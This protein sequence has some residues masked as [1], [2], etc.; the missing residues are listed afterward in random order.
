M[1]KKTKTKTMERAHT[2][3]SWTAPGI[4]H[5]PHPLMLY[6]LYVAP[7]PSCF[8][9]YVYMCVAMY[10]MYMDV[11]MYQKGIYSGRELARSF[12]NNLSHAF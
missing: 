6:S 12:Q 4:G 10:I 7:F 2:R 8:Y 3:P 1:M 9:V 5:R 11:Y